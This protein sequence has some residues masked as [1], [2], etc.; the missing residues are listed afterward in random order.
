MPLSETEKL[1]LEADRRFSTTREKLIYVNGKMKALDDK[2]KPI[3]DTRG[4]AVPEHMT[5]STFYRTLGDLVRKTGERTEEVSTK[6]LPRLLG[7]RDEYEKQLRDTLA[8]IDV[9]HYDKQFLAVASL[10]RF[11]FE[12][13]A[14]LSSLDEE[15]QALFDRGGLKKYEKSTE[16][17]AITS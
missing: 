8:D 17:I 7:L 11:Y 2:G 16:A 3:K 1:I 10:R 12:Y 13:S 5:K 9:A 6:L 14:Y 15:I 4:R